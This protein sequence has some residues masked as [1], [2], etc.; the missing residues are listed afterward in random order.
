MEEQDVACFV[1]C[2][3]VCFVVWVCSSAFF[4][5]PKAYFKMMFKKGRWM[6][7]L[8]MLFM[9]FLTLF[10]VIVVSARMFTECSLNVP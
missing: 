10:V 3:I 5:G 9:M 1:F 2:L 7:T 8:A 4:W 6:S